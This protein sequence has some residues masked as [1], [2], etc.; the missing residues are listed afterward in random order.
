M[1]LVSDDMR[2]RFLETLDVV[3]AILELLT[4]KEQEINT[5]YE[6]VESLETEIDKRSK[7]VAILKWKDKEHPAPGAEAEEEAGD[8]GFGGVLLVE[9]VLPMRLSM[10]EILSSSGFTISGEAT[11]LAD[12]ITLVH[13]KR[14]LVVILSAR[15]KDSTGLNALKKLREHTP[16][17]KA[18]L[19]T[20][21]GDIKEVLSAVKMGR[22]EVLAKPLNR[23]RLVETVRSLFS[24][25]MNGMP[26][27]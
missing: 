3:Q 1:G 25:E 24:D 22:I 21:T 26:S 14:P 17:L 27:E 8:D 11:S 12:A 16:D 19:V 4:K 13:E 20:D 7:E 23:L 10:K 6:R 18:V 9:P 2:E 15:L 5:L